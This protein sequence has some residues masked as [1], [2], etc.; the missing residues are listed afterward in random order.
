M[1]GRRPLTFVL[2]ASCIGG[3]A[4]GCRIERD[5]DDGDTLHP[6]GFADPSSAEFHG[7]YLAARGYPLEDCRACHGDD[8]HGGTVQ[9]SCATAGCHEEGVESCGTC[10]EVSPTTG[11]HA[12]H[13]LDCSECHEVPLDARSP[14]HP[15]GA[16][17]LSFGD[18][19]SAFQHEPRFDPTKRTCSDL[20]CHGGAEISWDD[21]GP[22]A[23][24]SCHG[25]PPES[26]A[27]FAS[28]EDDCEAC[29]AGGA[30]VDARLDVAALA[31]NACHGKGPLGA[32]P[33]GLLLDPAGPGVG[34]H[35]R[36]LDPSLPN[37]IGAV[38]ACRDCH[39][40][41]KTIGAAGH[42]DGAAPADVGLAGGGSYDPAQRSCTSA[43]HFDVDPGPVWTDTSG[44]ARACDACH[45][46]PPEK[47]R[48]GTTHPPVPGGAA[49]C[50]SCH[51]FDPSTHVDG[52]V[53]FTW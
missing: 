43:C 42:L 46:M 3:A 37:R 10:H 51:P 5:R 23:C 12:A 52:V 21:P 39:V 34:A 44:A 49:A 29:H 22:L 31:C 8:Y 28:G 7:V 53:D 1:I 19:A 30:H 48:T 20:Y 6:P 45:G 11:A 32:P 13:A 2:V 25:A 40:V 16:V 26:H 9:S 47:T 18:L 35:A 17:E 15:S 38:A 41:P 33:A 27:R 4:Y 14:S 24:S 36:H 50:G